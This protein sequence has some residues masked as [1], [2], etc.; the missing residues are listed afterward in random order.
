MAAW[1]NC[2]RSHRFTWK[3]E[4][5]SCRRPAGAAAMAL[6]TSVTPNWYRAMRPK[7]GSAAA[8]H[9]MSTK[10]SCA[11]MARSTSA[12]RN[13]YAALVEHRDEGRA[14]P[15]RSVDLQ[16]EGAHLP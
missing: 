15:P 5:L 10:L 6:R 12:R 7:A 8:A 13:N 4:K 1:R 3:T 14:V 9:E 11:K 16:P 2:L